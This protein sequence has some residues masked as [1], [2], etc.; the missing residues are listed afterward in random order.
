MDTDAIYLNIDM[1]AAT[2]PT[3]AGS[4]LN[5][6]AKPAVDLALLAPGARWD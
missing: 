6:A 3:A 4:W 1:P 2:A 5:R